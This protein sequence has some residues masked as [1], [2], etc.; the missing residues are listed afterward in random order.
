MTVPSD[1]S[2]IRYLAAK[3]SVD[4]RSLNGRVL[5]SLI[6]SLALP[7]TVACLDFLEVGAGIGTMVE[8]FL[9]W[10]IP[11]DIRYTAIDI[12]SACIA[13]ADSRIS[14]RAG[15]LGYLVER[16]SD[17]SI[18][19]RGPRHETHIKFETA[20]FLEYLGRVDCSG[21]RDLIIANAFLDLVD[22][23]EI[24]P[25]LFALLKP[26]GFLYFTINF[27]GMTVLEPTIDRALDERIMRLYHDSMDTR[28]VH[29]KPSGD[30]RTGRNLFGE[31]RRSG[32]ELLEA[33]SS[34]WVVYAG[35]QGY[36]DDDA[37]FLHFILHLI[38]EQLTGHSELDSHSFADW[39]KR[40]HAQIEDET[41]VYIAHQLDFLGRVP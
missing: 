7:E 17:G 6:E 41:L 29:G 33:G 12:D 32:V 30:S 27:D 24:L 38:E 11:A 34:D 10:G 40:R 23:G 14:S 21:T 28:R 35:P 9:E 5:R 13:E 4:D 39:I 2:F 26:G 1:Y 3:K 16:G 37:Y 25:S 19:L 15:G 18:H 36:I 22:V 31:L 8:R 20:D